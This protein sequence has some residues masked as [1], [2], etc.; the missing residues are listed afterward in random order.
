[1]VPK[2]IYTSIF[3]GLLLLAKV[4]SSGQTVAADYVP[5]VAARYLFAAANQ[6]RAARGLAPL[7]FDPALALAALQHAREM[8]ARG[9]ISHQF[10]GEASL[11]QRASTAGVRFSEIAE[12]VAAS[13]DSSLIHDLWMHSPEHRR[14]LLDPR[15]TVVGIAV[16]AGNGRFYAVEDFADHVDELSYREQEQ[17]VAGLLER[18]GLQ[19]LNENTRVEDAR[20]TCRMEDGYAGTR[21]PWFIMRYT[22]DR[23]NRLPEELESRINSGQ[24]SQAVVGACAMTGATPFSGYRIA[25]LLYP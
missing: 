22:S 24:Y 19:V 5:N 14:N 7:R 11:E 8:A 20:K 23:L 16:V 13:S 18:E 2:R 10:P 15:V 6:A 3:A 1:M 25:V 9:T 21:K 4:A 12:N 17:A